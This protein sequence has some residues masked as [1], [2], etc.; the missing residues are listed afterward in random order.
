MRDLVAKVEKTVKLNDWG[1]PSKPQWPA[2]STGLR[3]SVLLA[4]AS[5]LLALS[6]RLEAA[7]QVEGTA[8]YE[9]FLKGI[10]RLL[11]EEQFC[12]LVE[13]ERW[14]INTRLVSTQ[15]PLTRPELFCP[16]RQSA[17]SDGN[18][19]YYLKEMAIGTG[20]APVGWVEPGPVPNMA[21]P[22]T[23]CLF[24]MAYCS[25]YYLAKAE[26]QELRPVWGTD[27][28]R[29]RR[30][31][32]QVRVSSHRSLDSPDYLDQLS[33][34]SD[35]RINPCNPS[36]DTTNIWPRPWAGG[37]TQAM[38]RVEKT[39]ALPTG[40]KVPGAF[41]FELLKPV[42]RASPPR[43]DALSAMHGTVATVTGGVQVVSWLPRLPKDQQVIVDDYRFTGEV[44]NWETVAYAVT[45]QWSARNGAVAK[46][47]ANIH[48]VINPPI[49]LSKRLKTMGNVLLWVGIVVLLVLLARW[50][51][52]Q[53]ERR[54]REKSARLQ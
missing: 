30:G 35:G 38:F 10:R 41:K 15:P 53:S 49:S 33:F 31:E 2:M 48:A 3:I 29:S 6:L 21:Q 34:L 51:T 23:V 17:G 19:V 12:A 32:C 1:S 46:A 52:R 50:H 42:P 7:T 43:L 26:R 18:D 4:S 24:W 16:Q 45:N 11:V 44:T 36:R 14:S 37:F 8:T 22:P 9:V 27:A 28:D 25:S 13:G 40:G 47:A 39:T 20:Q 54:A 5:C